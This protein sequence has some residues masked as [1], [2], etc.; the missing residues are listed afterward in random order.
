[1]L[2][3]LLHAGSAAAQQTRYEYREVHMGMPVRIVLYAGTDSLARAA[4]KAAFDT[5]ASLDNDLS[6]Y[7]AQSEV[8]RI[9]ANAGA[10][11][12][13]KPSTHDVLAQAVEIAR[14]SD[15]AFDPTIAPLVRIW[16][17]ARRRDTIPLPAAIDSA[18]A[19]VSWQHL[20]LDSVNPAARLTRRGMQLDLGGI[21]KGYVLQAAVRTLA[22]HGVASA[23]VEAGG[24]IVVGRRPP[25]RE[26]WHIDV[27]G[28]TSDFRERAQALENV[29]LATSG[30]AAQF[31]EIDGVRY[32]HVVD[33]RSGRGLTSAVS[34]HV[35]ASNAALADALATTLTIASPEIARDLLAK[36]PDVIV[37]LQRP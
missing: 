30:P 5:I 4:A 16:R 2:M 23:L 20:Q 17:D 18:R 29:A 37:T 22:R 13:I 34:A 6:D 21:A 27:P 9:E 19:L 32:S 3:L 11:V 36:F 12:R 1:M 24:D 28:A 14:L 10:W 7:R 35:I 26:G 31:I 8:R 33:P 15:G 25:D